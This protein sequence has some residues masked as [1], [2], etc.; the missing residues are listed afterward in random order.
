M[1]DLEVV[2]APTSKL[3]LDPAAT[4]ARLKRPVGEQATVQQVI[5]G[6]S[7]FVA[8]QITY[9]PWYQ[10]L[11]LRFD[12]EDLDGPPLDLVGPFVRLVSLVIPGDEPEALVVG[13]DFAVRR[14]GDAAGS[15]LLRRSNG[16]RAY[17]WSS[18][19]GYQL[20]ARYFAGWWLPG[21]TGTKPADVLTL[22][23]DL[24]EAA[25]RLVQLR[26]SGE[27]VNPSIR[28]AKKGSVEVEF[29]GGAAAG[30]LPADVEAVFARY[31]PKV[32]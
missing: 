8:G 22:P 28:T 27:R 24:A 6:V 11:I 26:H 9:D 12:A 17:A 14:A 15:A 31:R 21:M 13:E 16:W 25:F 5:A 23:E 18:G 2:T 20:E 19:D 32:V 3:L 4:T 29:W 7:Q 30:G 10:E 1:A